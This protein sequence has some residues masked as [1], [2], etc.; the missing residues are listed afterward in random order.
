MESQKG[1]ARIG[2]MSETY[3]ER[4]GGGVDGGANHLN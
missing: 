4:L 3:K 2:P 1:E